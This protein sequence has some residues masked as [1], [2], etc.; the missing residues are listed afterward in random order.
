MTTGYEAGA[1]RDLSEMA[2]EGRRTADGVEAIRATLADSNTRL[3]AIV[4]EVGAIIGPDEDSPLMR[5]AVALERI[6]KVKEFEQAERQDRAAAEQGL[7]RDEGPTWRM[8]PPQPAFV[9]V[10][11]RDPQ[12]VAAE[13]QA[14]LSWHVRDNVTGMVRSKPYLKL[15]HAEN[16]CRAMNGAHGGGQFGVY[17]QNGVRV[18]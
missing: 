18:P 12:E 3:E 9:E 14:E 7:H 11:V 8:G 4:N 6:A 17:D 10:P 1:Y 2:R 5:I 13:N 16:T 15:E